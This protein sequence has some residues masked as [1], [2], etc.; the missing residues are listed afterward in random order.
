MRNTALLKFCKLSV[1]IVTCLASWL[2]IAADFPGGF[3]EQPGVNPPRS[4]LTQ[5]QIQNMLPQRGK[6]TFPPPYNTEAIRLTNAGDCGGSDCL[7]YIGYSY[8]TNI[9]NHIGSDTM[10]IF[11]GMNRDRG[12]AGPSL[13]EYNKVTDEVT[14]LGPL[15]DPSEPLSWATGEGWYFS[16]TMPDALYVNSGASLY[17]YDVM[18]GE[19]T[20]VFD[21]EDLM[22]NGLYIWQ[23]HSS[24]DDRVHSV[25]VRDLN[26]YEMLGCM[27][28]WENS[29]NYSY[30]PRQGEFDECQI[31]KSGDWLLIKANIDGVAGEDNRIINLQTG[32]ER[33]LL[34]SEGAAGH[35]DMGFGYMIAADNWASRANSWK[36]W[37]FDSSQLTGSEVYSNTD[38]NVFAPAHVSHQ[39]ANPYDAPENQFACGSSLNRN[40]SSEANEI[41]CFGL[42]GADQALVV[43]PVMTSLDA[44]G[45]GDEY[46]MLPKGNLDI[47][48]RYFIWTSNM[49]GNRLDAF[50]VKIPSHLLGGTNETS[51]QPL[52]APDPAPEGNAVVDDVTGP[53][54]SAIKAS[55]I[56]SQSALITWQTDENAASVA[57]YGLSSDYTNTTSIKSALVT[58]HSATLSNL[59]P[60]SLYHYR[61]AARDASG[62]ITVSGDFTFSTKPGGE[63]TE[64][65]PEDVIWSGLF[66]VTDNGNS[67]TKTGGCD[68]CGDAGGNSWQSIQ[69]GDG[70]LEITVH[71]TQ[72][73]RFVGLSN[74]SSGTAGENIDFALRLQA[75]YVEVRE[76]G[77]YKA[78]TVVNSG[79]VLRVAIQDGKATYSNNG[80][81]FHTSTATPAYPLKAFATLYSMNSTLSNA[82]LAAGSSNAGP[83]TVPDESANDTI[84]SNGQQEPLTWNSLVNATASGNALAKTA[85]CDGCDD[86]GA[87]S[88]Q[89]LQDGNGFLEFTVYDTQ[90]LRFVG[91]ST[92]AG[93][94][95]A[96]DIDF[97]LRLQGGYAEVRE[98]GVY[99][100]DI[101]LNSGDSLRV[102]V[103]NGVVNY[104]RNGQV[105]YSSAATPNFPMKAYARLLSSDS[106]ISNAIGGG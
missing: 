28:Y 55:S 72:G 103:Q 106:R 65:Q 40:N 26:N 20:L 84:L 79:D 93:G 39:N 23:A 22:G 76:N 4:L 30:Y 27:V 29:G 80:E 34:D 44:S 58:S 46:A 75:G 15:F 54:L 8:W 52:P 89:Q 35:S 32:Q 102:S 3:L 19:F 36:L 81:T 57:Q 77:V 42:D 48:G 63:T 64:A 11:I 69:S 96:D 25:T 70:F 67:L 66:N 9:N 45:G 83:S 104:A 92:V 33:R 105:F 51:I 16:A 18:T 13:I 17:R 38:W 87:V 100:A 99:R 86:A 41:I 50:L 68:G 61:V 7:A 94:T 24:A 60:G 101:T 59:S 1:V 85:G 91:L 95:T 73:L 78:D 47:T 82:V 5:S 62:N 53:V 97:A 6:F 71:D 2:A 90:S 21:V 56:T 98:N 10:H 74:E 88:G 49:G 12:G 31:D 43:A 37:K 14:N